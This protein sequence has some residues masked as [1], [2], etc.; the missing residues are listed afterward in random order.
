MNH[1]LLTPNTSL[2]TLNLFTLSSIPLVYITV[3]MKMIVLIQLFLVVYF[4]RTTIIYFVTVK[5]L[6]ILTNQNFLFAYLKY[7]VSFAV[8]RVFMVTYKNNETTK[9]H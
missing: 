8:A 3:T 9:K 1:F 7:A 2:Y 6:F 5:I 4:L